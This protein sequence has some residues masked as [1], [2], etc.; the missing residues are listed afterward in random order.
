MRWYEREVEEHEIE[1]A[2]NCVGILSGVLR[3]I[4]AAVH[5]Y[6]TLYSSKNVVSMNVVALRLFGFG[7]AA[8]S[9]VGA[10]A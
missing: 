1:E 10:C 4:T 2:V 3:V 6:E 7:R 8:L 5:R 9:R